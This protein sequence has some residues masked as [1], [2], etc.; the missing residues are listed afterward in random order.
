MPEGY[1]HRQA[2]TRPSGP[3]R[4]WVNTGS[5]TR[6]GL[7]LIG[8]AHLRI[9]NIDPAQAIAAGRGEQYHVLKTGAHRDFQPVG[10]HADDW[11]YEP[12][13][14][15]GGVDDAGQQGDWRGQGEQRTHPSPAPAGARTVRS[16]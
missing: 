2:H 1:A 4:A 11:V 5:L 15:L 12:G 7:Q 9:T 3:V 10:Q 6:F 8:L 13:R 14:R 16:E